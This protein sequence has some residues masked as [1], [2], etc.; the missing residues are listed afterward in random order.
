MKAVEQYNEKAVLN[1]T[2]NNDYNSHLMG[3]G[4]THF[5]EYDVY[6][7]SIHFILTS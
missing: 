6:S 4:K 5:R 1:L 3:I 2:P 7:C